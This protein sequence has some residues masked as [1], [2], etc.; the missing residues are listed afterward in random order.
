M[1]ILLLGGS[2]LLGSAVKR[3]AE[4][5]GHDVIA[6]DSKD[7]NLLNK[8]HLFKTMMHLL[9]ASAH[10][11]VHP[12]S[13]IVINCAG[14]SN[15][16]FVNTRL[17][18]SLINVA[19]PLDI[20]NICMAYGLKYVH[21]RSCFETTDADEPY[22][23]SKRAIYSA[24]KCI[25]PGLIY[26]I[27]PGWLFGPDPN[28]RIG[29]RMVTIAK[30]DGDFKATNDRWFS[31][32]YVKDVAEGMIRTITEKPPGEYVIANQ[33]K[34]TFYDVARIIWEATGSQGKVIPVSSDDKIR[35]PKD[36]SI[37]GTMRPWQDAIR[38]Y[39]ET[40]K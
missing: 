23:H 30:L 19:G 22:T 39:L 28:N 40:M 32:S 4:E 10:K 34:A 5:A 15:P 8:N 37:E 11:N 14:I 21:I 20:A 16:D 26:Y 1:H 29:A 17:Y 6:P 3:V 27:K 38:E 9:P 25:D 24:L 31:P 35:R 2:G 18:L 13:C 7:F 12:R 33:G 36:A